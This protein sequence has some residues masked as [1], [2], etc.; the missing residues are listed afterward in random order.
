MKCPRDI[1]CIV[2][3]SSQCNTGIT[4]LNTKGKERQGSHLAEWLRHVLFGM[5]ILQVRVPVFMHCFPFQL[6][7]D[8]CTSWAVAG[9]SHPLPDLDSFWV[10]FRLA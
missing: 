9:D 3:A 7:D 6:P 4:N 5:P 2:L 1:C 10:D 8:A